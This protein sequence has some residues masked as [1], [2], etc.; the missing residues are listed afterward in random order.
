MSILCY[1]W[2]CQW[3]A[4]GAFRAVDVAGGAGLLIQE[5]TAISPKSSHFTRRFRDFGKTNISKTTVHQPIP[6]SQNAIPAFNWQHAGRKASVSAPWLGNKIKEN[7]RGWTTVAPSAIAQESETIQSRSTTKA[8]KKS[9]KWFS[10]GDSTCCTSWLR[11]MEIPHSRLFI[12]SVLSPLTN[13]RT[14]EYG[15]SFENRIRL[16]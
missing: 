12:A 14:D 9:T 7:E 1:R 5:A 3:L 6:K 13:Q 10:I 8:F 15:G 16:T 2:F 4:F 11:S